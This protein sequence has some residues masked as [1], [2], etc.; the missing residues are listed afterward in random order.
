MSGDNGGP[1]DTR[2]AITAGRIAA[3]LSAAASTAI[4]AALAAIHALTP[5]ADKAIYFTSASAAALMDMPAAARTFLATFSATPTLATDMQTSDAL[6]LNA[7]LKMFMRGGTL[8]VAAN[9]TARLTGAVKVSPAIGGVVLYGTTAN[10]LAALTRDVDVD[11]EVDWH[12]RLEGTPI[13]GAANVNDLFGIGFV[14][15]AGTNAQTWVYTGGVWYYLTEVATVPTFTSQG[16]YGSSWNVAGMGRITC[17]AG[18]IGAGARAT[19]FSI[20]NDDET[21]NVVDS[22]TIDAKY[23]GIV[24]I[25]SASPNTRVFC[26]RERKVT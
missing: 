13:L 15:N 5:A 19:T 10:R 7:V 17:A 26:P 20:G 1:D 3:I 18:T 12:A 9:W 25:G 4:G 23:F 11:G 8:P 14:D 21:W 2:P 24:M 16:A 22:D 6:S